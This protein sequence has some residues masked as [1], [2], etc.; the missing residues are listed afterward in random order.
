MSSSENKFF[1]V[2]PTENTGPWSSYISHESTAENVTNFNVLNTT[3]GQ[4]LFFLNMLHYSKL[5]ETFIVYLWIND[6]F[7][8]KKIPL[9]LWNFIT[10]WSLKIFNRHSEKNCTK[11][12]KQIFWCSSDP[13]EFML[14]KF[15]ST[16]G[17]KR[18]IWEEKTHFSPSSQK[19][20]R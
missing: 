13:L 12:L 8:E 19:Y 3:I 7:F 2:L 4:F 5:F 11:S 9:H 20:L 17:E 1:F 10:K 18:K 16:F 14:A 15:P 6:T